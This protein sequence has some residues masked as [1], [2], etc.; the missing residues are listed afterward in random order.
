MDASHGLSPRSFFVLAFVSDVD[1]AP[2][3]LQG[4]RARGNACDRGRR[5]SRLRLHPGQ[6][7]FV[8]TIG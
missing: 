1:R 4:A 6:E 8:A 3:E 7:I 5:S 2:G